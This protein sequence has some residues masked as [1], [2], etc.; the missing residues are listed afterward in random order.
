MVVAVLNPCVLP[1]SFLLPL[2]SSFCGE[3]GAFCNLT[4][5]NGG[6]KEDC[7]A[8]GCSG[9]PKTPTVPFPK[10]EELKLELRGC[11]DKAG[12]WGGGKDCSLEGI[13]VAVGPYP[14]GQG[15][16]SLSFAKRLQETKAICV[17]SRQ[18]CKQ[19]PHVP[20]G[21]EILQSTWQRMAV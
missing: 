13:W 11:R 8:M 18:I 21:S 14:A 17:Y 5:P 7:C 3:K 4:P 16:S 6:H 15:M 1:F 19:Q 12:S 2:F 10:P 20:C 9:C